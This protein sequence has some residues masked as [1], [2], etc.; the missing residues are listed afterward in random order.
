M[1][2][3]TVLVLGST[4]TPLGKV[5]SAKESISEPSAWYSLIWL[6]WAMKTMW[7]TGST[8][9]A[10]ALELNGTPAAWPLAVWR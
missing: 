1:A 7:V 8:A 2:T 10:L 9:I 5:P 3:Y 6:S 4:A